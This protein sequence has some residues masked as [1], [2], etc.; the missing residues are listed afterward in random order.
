MAGTV[1][2]IGTRKGL[3]VLESDDGRKEWNARGPFC[4]S[5]PVYH[6]LHDLGS[7]TIYA[8]AA[9]E[10]FGS[11][12]WRSPDLGETWEH[13][14]EGIS[15]GDDDPRK[16]SKVSSLG[17]V[18]GRVLVGV[19]APGIFESA[20]GGQTWSLLTTLA[21]QPGSEAWDDPANQ[22]PGHLGI[23]AI[24]TAGGDADHWWTIVQG[25]GAFETDDGGTSW[26]PRNRGLRADWPREH[27]E[28]GFCVH[29]LV[30]S[31]ADG[32]RMYQQNH[33]GMH[34]SD[35]AGH[36]WVEIT[37]GLPTEFG[38]AAA[39]HPYDRDTF[40]V[41]PLD[42]G[43]GR[44]MPEGQAAVWRTRDGGE[45]WQRLDSGL[46]QHD[47]YLGVLALEVPTASAKTTMTRTGTAAR[48]VVHGKIGRVTSSRVGFV[49]V[50]WV[51]SPL[52]GPV[53]GNVYERFSFRASAALRA[54]ARA[55]QW[56]RVQRLFD[57]E[58]WAF[59]LGLD[60]GTY[61]LVGLRRDG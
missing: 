30:R 46:P 12:V 58:T 26:T 6:A 43:H 27:E 20:D 45:K 51:R 39:A 34:R 18:D 49:S 2:L 7:G 42:P 38:F 44:T 19:E 35:D 15:Y 55:M 3:F 33:V 54:K 37:D 53:I 1:L 36:S 21:G 41:I 48:I 13:S 29:K 40:Y 31:G 57:R 50:R 16:V 17:L 60:H 22:P 23:S 24:E 10:W 52:G 61:R 56:D 5:W 25:I 28:V 9:S 11:A 32:N 8:A 47:A 14:S 59:T 4:E